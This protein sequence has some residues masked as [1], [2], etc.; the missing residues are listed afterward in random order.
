M[1]AALSLSRVTSRV[2]GMAA[3]TAASLIVLVIS[4]PGVLEAWLLGFILLA[5]LSSGALALLLTG[6]ILGEIWLQPI[7]AELEAVADLVPMMAILAVPILVYPE[8]LYPWAGGDGASDWLDPEFF[9]IRGAIYL[10]VWVAV[11]GLAKQR[12]YG[13][14]ASAIGLVVLVPSTSLAALDWLASREPEW[15]SGL[16]GPAFAV[17]QLLAAMAFG[18][19]V[20]LIRPGHPDRLQAESLRAALLALALLTLW[21][22]FSQFLI[23]WMANLPPEGAWYIGRA[24]AWLVL[25]GI[26]LSALLVAVV[27]LFPP[28]AGPLRLAVITGLLIVQHGAHL[29]WLIRPTALHAVPPVLDIVVLTVMI[30][31]WL[32]FLSVELTRRPNLSLTAQAGA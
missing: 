5:G 28:H 10:A 13:P 8:A 32:V 7:R 30:G 20:T 22:W 24:G 23:V 31:L 27:L 25:E 12:H 11:A 1:S 19:I 26:A 6:H 18:L 9:L 17:S 15:I 16:Y 2:L 21:T 14:V 3:A 29:I 4:N